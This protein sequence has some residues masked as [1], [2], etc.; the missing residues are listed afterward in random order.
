MELFCR[1]NREQGT[2]VV[3]VTHDASLL[4][5][6]PGKVYVCENEKCLLK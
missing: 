1:I 5:R 3:V 4:E 2:A 6:Y